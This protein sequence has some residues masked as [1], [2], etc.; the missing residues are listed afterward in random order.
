MKRTE[1]AR[2][3][4]L[5][6]K[7]QLQ[8]TAAKP[9]QPAQRS[10]AGTKTPRPST[11]IPQAARDAVAAR[12]GGRCEIQA[13]GPCTGQATDVHHRLRRRDGGHDVDN[14]LHACRHCHG[15]A[16]A[17]PELARAFGWIVS[18]WSSPGTTPLMLR[19]DRWVLLS[20]GYTDTEEQP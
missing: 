7:S 3:A 11:T 20:D 19:G 18:A 1:L 15:K 6:R 14:L 8:R 10:T 9:R 5:V 2:G 13:P 17:H 16:H 4:P 12:S